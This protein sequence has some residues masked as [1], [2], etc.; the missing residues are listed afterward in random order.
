MSSPET[1][2]IG[3]S[4][5][6]SAVSHSTPELIT[7]P[8]LFEESSG[9]VEISKVAPP[10]PL[11]GILAELK[12]IGNPKP[13]S[14]LFKTLEEFSSIL[15]A[16]KAKVTA[17]GSSSSV[18][19]IVKLSE[20]SNIAL[21][22][23]DEPTIIVSS[24]SSLTSWTPVRVNVPVL[25]PAKISIWFTLETF[26]TLSFP[27]SITKISPEIF[28][29][30]HQ[31][32]SYWLSSVPVPVPEI[33]VPSTFPNCHFKILSSFAPNIKSPFFTK[34]VDPKPVA[35]TIPSEAWGV[36]FTTLLL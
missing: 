5:I 33:T 21:T 2:F 20:D 3:I 7:F 10:A 28:F 4:K 13:F 9:S 22:G 1:I 29:L 18:M 32:P 31:I 27:L 12:R 8:V 30:I 11:N 36:H 26:C 17:G 6:I 19:V 15:S 23:S 35:T 16:L 24:S 14:W 25:E 34:F